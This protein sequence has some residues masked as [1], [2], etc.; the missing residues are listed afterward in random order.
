MS[1]LCDCGEVMESTVDGD[2]CEFCGGI[3]YADAEEAESK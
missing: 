3:V 1:E 2:K